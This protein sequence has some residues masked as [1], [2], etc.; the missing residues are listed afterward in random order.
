MLR[1]ALE[2]S[3]PNFRKIRR[4][5]DVAMLD[6]PIESRP[7]ATSAAQATK[8]LQRAE[9]FERVVLYLSPRE[10]LSA[11]QISKH[12]Q[13]F[14]QDSN[15]INAHLSLIAA[16]DRFI[17]SAFKSLHAEDGVPTIFDNFEV[18]YLSLGFHYSNSGQA[19]R[20]QQHR[21]NRVIVTARFAQSKTLPRIGSRCQSM[22]ICQ[23]RSKSCK[24]PSNAART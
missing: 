12:A 13:S 10:A 17:D 22:L 4:F 14:L 24:S 11:I 19:N 21:K 15:R 3:G 9:L 6:I 20:P 18:T 8:T 16:K 23:P 7:T 5:L 1:K 2:S